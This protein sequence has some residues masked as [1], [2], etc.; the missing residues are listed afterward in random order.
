LLISRI[1]P[2]IVLSKV[3]EYPGTFFNYGIYKKNGIFALTVDLIP[4]KINPGTLKPKKY[5]KLSH[6]HQSMDIQT[7]FNIKS[8]FVAREVGTELIL[9][10]LTGNVAQMS[11]LFTMNETAKFIWENITAETTV[12][13]IENS[14]TEAFDIDAETAHKDIENFLLRMEALFIKSEKK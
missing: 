3:P 4:Q 10:P 5:Y 11:E 6:L 2:A 12:E 1:N 7:L 14:M 8:K 13:D 9:V